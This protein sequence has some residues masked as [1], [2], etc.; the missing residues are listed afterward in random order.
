[1]AP[2]CWAPCRC[3]SEWPSTACRG[4]SP[5]GRSSWTSGPPQILQ[6]VTFP[7]PSISRSTTALPPGPAPRCAGS[8]RP[9]D[10]DLSRLRDD[11]APGRLE[12]IIQNLLLIGLDRARGYFAVE[13]L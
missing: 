13:A 12:Q 9:Y 3:P 8:L 2:P 6:R 10:Q 5:L 11:T 1:M 7:A 4:C